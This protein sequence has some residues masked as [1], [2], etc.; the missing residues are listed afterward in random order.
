MY[1]GY[2][3]AFRW[4]L[5]VSFCTVA[6][7]CSASPQVISRYSRA[8]LRKCV[9]TALFLVAAMTGVVDSQATFEDKV[10]SL[11]LG[12][13]LPKLNALG[14]KTLGEFAFA[15]NFTPGSSDDSK[16]MAN[17]AKPILGENMTLVPKLRRL[18]F[19]AYTLMAS[20]MKV[21]VERT[22]DDKPRK[23][24]LPERTAR[25]KKIEHKLA[26]LD[27]NGVHEVSHELVDKCVA[28]R[29]DRILRY[30][31]WESCTTRTEELD[32]KKTD[33][34]WK[35][36]ASGVIREVPGQASSTTSVGT[37][38]QLS[39]VFIRRG[40]ALEQGGVMLFSTH[41]KIAQR[42]MADLS[43]APP[44][45]YKKTSYTQVRN[46]DV[47]LFQLVAKEVEE[48]IRETGDHRTNV[49]DAVDKM[50]NDARF[51]TLLAPL[52]DS[53]RRAGSNDD[54]QDKKRR[55]KA[56]KGDKDWHQ[57]W[58]QWEVKKGD[59]NKGKGKKG[60]KNKGKG[61]GKVKAAP[62]PRE[63]VGGVSMTDDNESI[64][65]GYNCRAG[66]ALAQAGGYCTKGK[67]VCCVAGCFSPQH[68]FFSHVVAGA[69]QG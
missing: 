8:L 64:C 12:D 65:F 67:H 48:G 18:F 17:V 61:K 46:A 39:N 5:R 6:G 31:P 40:I 28:I 45:G 21:R 56:G 62:M 66:C 63:L 13:F 55:R 58:N 32:G 14:F 50:L 49:D 20:D 36:D 1:V 37:D 4:C 43:Y 27:I 9:E 10:K 69:Q 53:G 35:P 34:V 23:L 19:E 24:T 42:F 26:G 59:K 7:F 3:T 54:E 16:W 51:T 41:Q 68:A 22:D 30:V 11:G 57:G 29:E 44:P 25:K 47:R 15:E 38:Y 60:D 2:C 33:P 52:Q